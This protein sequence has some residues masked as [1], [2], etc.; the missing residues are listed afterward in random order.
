LYRIKSGTETGQ[1]IPTLV[2][3]NPEPTV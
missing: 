1:Y 3:Q 2:L